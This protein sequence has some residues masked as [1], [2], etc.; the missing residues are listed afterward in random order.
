VPL[1]AL[2]PGATDTPF[3]DAVGWA[4]AQVG[5]LMSPERVADDTLRA[6]ARRPLRPPRR[7]RAAELRVADPRPTPQ[8]PV[9]RNPR[10][11]SVQ[12]TVG[13]DGMRTEP[14]KETIY[15]VFQSG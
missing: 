15:Q 1:L 9:V 11:T 5:A 13:R 6:F 10:S 8:R 3:F 7:P 14:R 4:D 2:Y 12:R